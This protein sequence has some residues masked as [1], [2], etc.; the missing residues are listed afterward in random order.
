MI[1][2]TDLVIIGVL[3]GL[4]L[5]I[6]I[7]SLL[8][9]GIRWYKK[10]AHLCVR[11][12]EHNVS[13]PTL[14]I[15]TNG[16]GT[17]TDFSASLTNSRAIQGSEKLQKIPHR[18]WWKHQNKD[19]FVSTSGILRYSYKYVDLELCLNLNFHWCILCWY[20]S[21]VFCLCLIRPIKILLSR[22]Y[23]KHELTSSCIALVM[24]DLERLCRQIFLMKHLFLVTS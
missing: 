24:M 22:I 5:G 18:S 1:G 19:R 9:F 17:S 21:E 14:P 10:R 23:I 16:L 8:F 7:A 4:A 15:R 2:R 13:S 12:N 3:G 6:L 20:F 11:A